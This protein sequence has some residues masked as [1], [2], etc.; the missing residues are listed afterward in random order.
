[1]RKRLSYSSVSLLAFGCARQWGA[2]YIGWDG[3]DVSPAGKRLWEPPNVY[4]AA[5]SAVHAGIEAVLRA[6]QAGSD[7]WVDLGQRMTLAYTE[8]DRV[9]VKETETAGFSWRDRDPDLARAEGGLMMEAAITELVPTIDPLPHGI[10][11]EVE[12]PIPGTDWTFLAKIDCISQAA[13]G[14][15]VWVY[16]WKTGSFAWKQA[17]ADQSHQFTAYGWA[18]NERYGQVPAGYSVLNVTRPTK[19]NP[20]QCQE[21]ITKR[22]PQQYKWWGDVLRNAVRQAEGGG[23]IPNPAYTYCHSCPIRPACLPWTVKEEREF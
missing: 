9:W 10:E 21:I 7:K 15:A 17:Q 22:D 3:V 23:F 18:L 6:K 16:D 19:G 11:A 20:P 12:V 5:G 14:D 13:R 1:M 4:T 2:K 8:F